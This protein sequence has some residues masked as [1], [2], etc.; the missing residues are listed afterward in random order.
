MVAFKTCTACFDALTPAQRAVRVY[1]SLVLR[2]DLVE[3][4]G[5]IIDH[6]PFTKLYDEV[7]EGGRSRQSYTLKTLRRMGLALTD[8]EDRLHLYEVPRRSKAIAEAAEGLD[9][10]VR[11]LFKVANIKQINEVADG[12]L[13]QQGVFAAGCEHV[14]VIPA[15]APPP[16]VQQPV[17]VILCELSDEAVEAAIQNPEALEA[18]LQEDAN[19]SLSDD[20]LVRQLTNRVA[21]LR[22]RNDELLADNEGKRKEIEALQERIGELETQLRENGVTEETRRSARAALEV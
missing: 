10:N 13:P 5:R 18:S 1:T 20:E 12:T 21:S 6:R 3:P 11:H 17:P 19:D 16:V 4:N 15:A 22:S 8:S 7:V 9:V 14:T 2:P